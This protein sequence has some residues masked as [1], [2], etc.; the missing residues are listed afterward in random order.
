MATHPHA[1]TAAGAD[2]YEYDANGN[3]TCRIEA[4]ETF[5][6]AYDAENRLASV[7]KLASGTCAAPGLSSAEWEF[8][9]DGD[10]TRVSQVVTPYQAGQAQTPILTLYFMGGLYEET[11]SVAT[12]YYAI[13]G[14]TVA[15][16]NAGGVKYLLTDH[17][18][19]VDA[20]ADANGNVLSQQR[21]LPFGEVRT[22]DF[23]P[24]TIS[25][26]DFGYTGRGRTP[27]SRCARLCRKYRRQ[28]EPAEPAG[29]VVHAPAQWCLQPNAVHWPTC[30]RVLGLK[31]AARYPGHQKRPEGTPTIRVSATKSARSARR[32]QD[33]ARHTGN[34]SISAMLKTRSTEDQV[35][36]INSTTVNPTNTSLKVVLVS[37]VGRKVLKA[38]PPNTKSWST[39]SGRMET[40]GTQDQA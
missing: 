8:A 37:I 25:Q 1:A 24:G 40:F 30:P 33:T 28:R 3:M 11:E 35:P 6:Q 2:T 38:S 9:Y 27:R 23:A 22:D 19:S 12:K 20:I 21:Y 26:T 15:M 16:K 34:F 29:D 5:L 39:H 4:G 17:L 7:K 18:G 10:G 36:T 31:H 32:T 13:A 14:M